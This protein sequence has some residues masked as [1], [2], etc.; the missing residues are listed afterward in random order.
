[1][2]LRILEV[3]KPENFLASQGRALRAALTR[4]KWSHFTIF[5]NIGLK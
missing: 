1:L 5:L 2:K 3:Q 4:V